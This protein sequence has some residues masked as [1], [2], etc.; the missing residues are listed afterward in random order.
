[1]D[2]RLAGADPVL[3]YVEEPPAATPGVEDGLSARITLRL[4]G[5]LKAQVEQAASGDGVSANTWII[6][7]LRGEVERSWPRVGK[8]L[9]GFARS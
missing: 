2:V 5:K 7:A 8:R 6:Q 4:P 1:M 9:S 3:A